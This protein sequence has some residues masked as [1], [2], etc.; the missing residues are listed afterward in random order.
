[1][2][3]F[4]MQNCQKFPKLGYVPLADLLLYQC[5]SPDAPA[6]TV[7]W[8]DPGFIH[9]CFLKELWPNAVYVVSLSLHMIFFFLDVSPLK[10]LGFSSHVLCRENHL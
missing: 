6:R 1:M 10:R 7:G 4:A 9:T 5:I 3:H 2:I 8:R